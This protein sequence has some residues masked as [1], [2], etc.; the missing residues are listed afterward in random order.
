MSIETNIRHRLIGVW[1]AC[2][3]DTNGQ[4][5]ITKYVVENTLKNFFCPTLF[6]FKPGFSFISLWSWFSA[7]WRIYTAISANKFS[8]FYLV[9]S[10]SHWGFIR[11]APILALTKSKIPR[12]VHSHGGDIFDLLY[13]RWYSPI[14]RWLYAGAT[15]IVPSSH[16]LP[17]IQSSQV[18]FCAIDNPVTLPASIDR[19]LVSES[20]AE[21]S[22]KHPIKDSNS[23]FVVCWNSNLMCSKGFTLVFEACSVLYDE[24]VPLRFHVFGRPIGDHEMSKKRMQSFVYHAASYPWVV[25]HGTQSMDTVLSKIIESDVVTFP[26][27]HPTEAQGLAAV[28][29]MLLGRQLLVSRMPVMI[30]TTKGYPAIYI[31]DR[32]IA[33]V[34][35]GLQTAYKNKLDFYKTPASCSESIKKR[36]CADQ[37]NKKLLAVFESVSRVNT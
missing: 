21:R 11:D 29:A 20:A 17:S 35:I 3:E 1:S 5:I 24:G 12:I 10:R 34:K 36:F 32:S 9:V 8:V 6:I 31:D 15:I 25:F 33:A 16:L 23:P 37:F 22:Q 27:F 28:D 2:Y 7:F 13:H 30:E 18:K 4:A 14:V 19:R 26:T